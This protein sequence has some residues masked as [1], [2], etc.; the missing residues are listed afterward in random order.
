MFLYIVEN[1]GTQLAQ[2]DGFGFKVRSDVTT[3]DAF[4]HLHHCAT[5]TS[6]LH[7]HTLSLPALARLTQD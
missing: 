1:P 3:T 7:T 4:Y 5:L 2:T 6:A